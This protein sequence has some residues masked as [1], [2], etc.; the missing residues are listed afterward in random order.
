MSTPSS[1]SEMPTANTPQTPTS[2]SKERKW[3]VPV[4]IAAVVVGLAGLGV[5]IYAVATMPAKTSGP[6]GPVGPT[7]ATG[8]QGPRGDPGPAGP[9]GPAGTI[10]STSVVAGKKL[11]SAPDPPVGTVL[12]AR[13]ACPTGKILMSGGAQVS[14]P[15]SVPNRNVELR[16][17]LP[18]TPD[19]WETVGLVTGPLGAGV[20]MSIS[21]YVICGEA[22]SPT[23]T[24]TTTPTTPT[25]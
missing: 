9:S 8:A 14:A 19:I 7:G 1:A 25:T 2:A 11:I 10:A 5:G 13:T 24:T 21:P 22:S 3:V 23:T 6:P 16:S 12:A 4:L 18:V 17:S 20:S 15:G